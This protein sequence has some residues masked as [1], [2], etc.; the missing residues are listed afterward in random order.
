MAIRLPSGWSSTE[1]RRPSKPAARTRIESTSPS[2]STGRQSNWFPKPTLA[3]TLITGQANKHVMPWDGK[4]GMQRD[5]SL[6]FGETL[7]EDH[8]LLNIRRM[9]RKNLLWQR[10]MF[11]EQFT[12]GPSTSRHSIW[13]LGSPAKRAVYFATTVAAIRVIENAAH[14]TSLLLF[15]AFGGATAYCAYSPTGNF[16][17]EPERDICP[18]AGNKFTESFWGTLIS[19]LPICNLAVGQTTGL[20]KSWT[21]AVSLS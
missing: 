4:D 12:S 17:D 9:Y 3:A 19:G 1:L 6:R 15:L 20:T 5:D 21:G 2:T 13:D 10:L 8:P 16:S 18:S 14:L 11:P 7:D